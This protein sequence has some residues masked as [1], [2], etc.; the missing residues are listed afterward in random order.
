MI[1]GP[2]LGVRK[3]QQHSLFLVFAV[4]ILDRKANA[5]GR[6]REHGEL[7]DSLARGV[8]QRTLPFW[9]MRRSSG[10]VAAA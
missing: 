1:L 3:V 9:C 2:L 4:L 7:Y 5:P 10:A 6:A 8:A